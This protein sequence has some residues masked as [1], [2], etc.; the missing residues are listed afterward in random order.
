MATGHAAGTAA[1]LAVRA[2]TSPRMLDV[3]ILQ[4]TL[5]KQGAIL[6]LD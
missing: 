1:A 5:R 4:E 3:A 6:T 2:G